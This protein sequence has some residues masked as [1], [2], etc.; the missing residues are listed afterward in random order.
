MKSRTLETG[1]V[2]KKSKRSPRSF[3]SDIHRSA[4]PSLR[5][6]FRSARVRIHP[7]TDVGCR[8]CVPRASLTE[9]NFHPTK[10]ARRLIAHA[11]QRNYEHLKTTPISLQM[12]SGTGCYPQKFSILTHKLLSLWLERKRIPVE[13]AMGSRLFLP[14]SL[15]SI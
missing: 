9:R 7:G 13:L 1:D 6:F 15:L 2:R 8:K 12:L 10:R 4:F 5:I 11:S 3:G 14:K